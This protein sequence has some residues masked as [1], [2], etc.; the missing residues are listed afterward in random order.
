MI[1][2]QSVSQGENVPDIRERIVVAPAVGRFR[3]LPPEIFAS[4]GEWVEVGQALAEITINDVSIPVISPFRG[5]VMGMLALSGQ[6]VIEG[7]ALFW[8][9]SS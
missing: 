8:V 4:E 7:E 3:P 6:P 5:W 1:L 2:H 9:W